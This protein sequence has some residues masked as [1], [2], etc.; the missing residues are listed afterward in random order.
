MAFVVSI[1][2]S[3]C[4]VELPGSSCTDC[5][6]CGISGPT[7]D[8]GKEIFVLGPGV[9]TGGLAAV[10]LG[11]EDGACIASDRKLF[12]VSYSAGKVTVAPADGLA[13]LDDTAT[14]SDG[15]DTF[16][17]K[18]RS[19]SASFDVTGTTVSLTFTGPGITTKVACNGAQHV[20]TCTPG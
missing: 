16:T 4:S 18:D 3:G 5:G 15:N 2:S 9:T 20:I 10:D 8:P 6:A 14:S 13:R 7:Q 19:L 1:L 12:R 17:W 11:L